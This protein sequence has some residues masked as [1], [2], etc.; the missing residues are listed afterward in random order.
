MG[1][2]V[3]LFHRADSALVVD[4]R[5]GMADVSYGTTDING[6][7]WFGPCPPVGSGTHTYVFTLWALG[8]PLQLNA[9]ADGRVVGEAAEAA[10][11]DTVT[12]TATYE[13]SDAE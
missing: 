5:T 10:A 3:E 13:R 6:N 12:F 9:P 4:E 7:E 11:L 2:G 8:A 1:S